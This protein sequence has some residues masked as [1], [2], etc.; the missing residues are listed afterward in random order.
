[1][2]L[3][4]LDSPL[5]FLPAPGLWC[6]S[7]VWAAPPAQSKSIPQLHVLQP[8][9]YRAVPLPLLRDVFRGERFIFYGHPVPTPTHGSVGNTGLANP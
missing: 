8:D 1:M 4:C 9:V 2:R 6:P 7:A 5:G 3:G